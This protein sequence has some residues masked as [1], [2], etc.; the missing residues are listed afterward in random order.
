MVE[1]AKTANGQNGTAAEEEKKHDVEYADA[2]TAGIVSYSTPLNES[3]T[4]TNAMN[5]AKTEL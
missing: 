3:Y 2:E 1:E 4:V 5:F